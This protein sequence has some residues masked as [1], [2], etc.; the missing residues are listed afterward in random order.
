MTMHTFVTIAAMIA[1]LAAHVLTMMELRPRGGEAKKQAE[2]KSG[3][4]L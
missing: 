3:E 2:P 4:M 1:I